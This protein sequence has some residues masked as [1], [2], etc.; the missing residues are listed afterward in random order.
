MTPDPNG[1]VKKVDGVVKYQLVKEDPKGAQQ[2][3][4]FS[5]DAA[6][7]IKRTQTGASAMVVKKVL[8]VD[9]LEPGQYTLKMTATDLKRNQTVTESAP[10][11]VN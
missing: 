8:R 9:G 5:E 2:V 6:D 1:V 10:F 4:E 7:V 3:A 11:T